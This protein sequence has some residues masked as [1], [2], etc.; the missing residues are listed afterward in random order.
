MRP[1]SAGALL[2]LLA[3]WLAGAPGPEQARLAPVPVGPDGDVAAP[4]HTLHTLPDW[5]PF[6]G[7]ALGRHVFLKASQQTPYGL[8]HEL[9]HVRQQLAQ[10]AWFW[11][12]YLLLPDWR[13]RW[14]AEAYAV[15]ARARCPVDGARG[16]AAYLAGPAY[17]WPS[18][19]A[20]AAAAI[21]AFL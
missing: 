9:V 2:L 12:S 3:L 21:R 13:L 1:R 8:G 5:L 11:V 18:S 20:E 19:Q 10:P 4:G 7:L 15:H 6:G 17:L 14:E 16:L